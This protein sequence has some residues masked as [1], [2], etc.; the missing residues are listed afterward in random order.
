ML[1]K[2]LVTLRE[3]ARHPINRR[4]RLRAVFRYGLVQVAARLTPGPVC[5]PFPN[6]TVL[7]VSPRM[8]GAAHFIAPGLC[9]FEVMSFVMHFLRPNDLFIDVGANVGAYTVLASGVAGARALS[10]E[11]CPGTFWYLARNVKLNDLEARTEPFNLALGAEEGLIHLTEGLGTENYVSAHPEAGRT[12]PVR[13][14]S[15]DKM[16]ESRNPVLLKIDVEGF[17]RQVLAGAS[18]TLANPALQAFVIERAGNANR[19]GEDESILHTQIRAQ[20]FHPCAY[21]ALDRSLRR[22]GPDE[23]GNLIYLRDFEAV[24]RRLRAA[25]AYRFAGLNV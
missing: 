3:V 25:P 5:V 24:E 23:L 16:L 6:E 20:G 4:A 14:T 7:L 18:R 9:E 15:L 13:V 2:L 22:L 17:E 10:F 19:Y 12:T 8:K 11:P 1:K 21:S